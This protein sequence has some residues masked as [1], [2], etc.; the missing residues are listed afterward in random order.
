MAKTVK[1]R[2]NLGQRQLGQAPRL[3]RQ[4]GQALRL[5]R[6]SLVNNDYSVN[7]SYLKA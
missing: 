4:L 6:L 1:S 5:L 3:R 2:F 7:D